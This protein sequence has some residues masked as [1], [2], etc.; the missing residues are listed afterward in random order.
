MAMMCSYML[1]VRGEGFA[2]EFADEIGY[3]EPQ[4]IYFVC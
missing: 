3:F 2:P 4:S 1:V